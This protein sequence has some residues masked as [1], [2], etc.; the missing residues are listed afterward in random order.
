MSQSLRKSKQKEIFTIVENFLR[1]PKHFAFINRLC[2]VEVVLTKL[3]KKAKHQEAISIIE[4]I[5]A[6]Y[7][8]FLQFSLEKYKEMFANVDKP[9]RE[10]EKLSNW[11]M[12]DFVN[13]KMNIQKYHKGIN[14]AMKNHKDILDQKASMSIVEAKRN[15]YLHEDEENM[16]SI[17]QTNGFIYEGE[18][19][20]YEEEDEEV[21]EK[22][23]DEKA[24]E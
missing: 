1:T 3:R 13:L 5:W 20:I 8:N 14:R 4:G 22:E 16:V 6:Y 24:L 15:T 2:W 11:H 7:T 9:I 19:S 10:I 18:L 17:M 23:D 12:E 21:I